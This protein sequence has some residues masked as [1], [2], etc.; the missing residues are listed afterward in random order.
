M[1]NGYNQMKHPELIT[2]KLISE[3][4]DMVNTVPVG[5]GDP[6]LMVAPETANPYYR[7]LFSVVRLLEPQVVVECGT[8]LGTGTIYM[9]TGCSK[10]IVVTIDKDIRENIMLN[11]R[12]NIFLVKGD[13][14]GAAKVVKEIIGNRKIGL[15]FLDSTHDGITP[16]NEFFAYQPFFDNVCIVACDDVPGPLATRD[17]MMN[18]WHSLPGDK[19]L[20]PLLHPD[21]GYGFVPGFGVCIVRKNA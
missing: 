10:S 5:V 18:F 21:L 20:L 13:T 7:F 6:Y 1:G 4:A 15:L 17:A 19:V 11:R 14:I 12:S 16:M 3:L 2:V 9:A 8:Y